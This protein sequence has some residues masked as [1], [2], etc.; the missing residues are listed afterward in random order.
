MRQNISEWNCFLELFQAVIVLGPGTYTG[1]L[2]FVPLGGTGDLQVPVQYT[3]TETPQLNISPSSLVFYSTVGLAPAAQTLSVSSTIASVGFTAAAYTNVGGSWL[4]ITPSSGT[5]PVSLSVSVNSATLTAGTYIGAIAVTANSAAGTPQIVSVSLTV[6]TVPTIT[7]APTSLQF[8]WQ[9]GAANP[10]SQTFAVSSSGGTVSAS[11]AVISGTWLGVTPASGTTPATFTVAVAPTNLGPG[12]Y[13]GT[14]QV[15]SPGAVGSPLNI[16]VTLTVTAAPSIAVTPT[17]LQYSFQIAGTNP[18]PQSFTVTST[19]PSVTASAAVASGSFL[20]VSPAS[21][22]TP[23][24]FTVAVTPTNL[25]PGAYNGTIQVTSP[26]AVGSPLNIPVTLTI[27]AAPGIAVT[28]TSLQYSFQVAG[29]NPPSQ[30]F[31]VTSSGPAITV[32]AAAASGSF[33]SVSPTAGTTPATFTVAVNTA[34]LAAGTHAGS[35]AVTSQGA[36]NS[37]Q[38]VNVTLTVANP[39]AGG[40]TGIV[41]AASYIA[42]ALSPGE[43]IT[44]GGTGLGPATGVSFSLTS[45]NTVAATL[46]NTQVL[47]DGLAAPLLY[48]SANQI[49]AIVPYEVAGRFTTSVQVSYNGILSNSLVMLVASTAPG[50]FA[51]NQAGTGQGAILNQDYSSN[52]PSTPAVKGSVVQ[53]FGTGEGQT[54]PPGITGSLSSSTVLRNPLQQPVTATVGGLPATVEF[55]GA[56]PTLVAGVFQVNVVIPPDA[57]SGSDAI[58]ISFGSNSSTQ[59]NVTVAVQ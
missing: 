7:V 50:I 3:V 25:G 35:V 55:A 20:S 14:I 31:T 1:Y 59:A 24:T 56:A 28:P 12:A 18:P 22:T 30:S 53:I 17:S 10:S 6:A 33:L 45:S 43:L 37:P 16:S 5:T 54:T 39:P 11:A 32:S 19:G 9:A 2:A 52:S 34:G 21:G 42:G 58:V 47:F 38:A 29:S 23:A 46:S 27:T 40:L 4:S 8:S 13:N 57:P 36:S 15:T 48:V 41:N 51:A 44:L 49:N 26:G